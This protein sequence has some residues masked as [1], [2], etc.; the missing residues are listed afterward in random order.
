VSSRPSEEVS[1]EE[2]QYE[3]G[4]DPKVLDLVDVPLIG[5]R[6][7][8]YQ[9]ENWLLD[10][11]YYWVRHGR[12]GWG[13]LAVLA[14]PP[15]VLWLN[16]FSTYNGLNGRVPEQAATGLTTSLTLLRAEQVTLSVLA[17]GMAFGNS[18]RQVYGQ[19]QYAGT[20]YKLRVTDPVYERHYL[21]QS[22]GNYHLGESYLTVSL[23]DLWEGFA[24][25]LIAAIIPKSGG[26][27]L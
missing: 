10:P 12:V 7:G 8:I 20:Y 17:P 2:R 15:G 5:P 11:D 26:T 21:A 18:K 13:D 27:T 23:G 22:N 6:P 1:E 25:K 24:Y 4:S 9:Q 19:F 16:G 14:D 3:D